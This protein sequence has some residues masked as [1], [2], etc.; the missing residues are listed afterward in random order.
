MARKSFVT[1]LPKH[2]FIWSIL[3]MAFIPL[4]LMFIIS[5]KDNVQFSH[6]PWLPTLPFHW[7]NY[8]VGWEHV[9]ASIWN[10]MF[11]AIS[12]TVLSLIFGVC[13]AFFFARYKMP[14]SNILFYIF[15]ILMLYPGVANMVPTFK[16]ISSLGLYNTH[17]ALILLFVAGSQAFTIYVMRNFIEDL[18]QDLFDAADVDGCSPWRQIWTIVVPL[19]SPIIGTLGVLR[20]IGEW[21]A[22]VGPLIM[23]RDPHKQMIGVRL[24]FL[25]G[26]Y[27]K[28][29]GEM[30]SGYTIASIP[31][32]I[33]F[34]FC[35]RLFV[36]GLSE[37]AIKG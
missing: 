35:M 34:L 8:K 25:E 3:F 36:R 28:K 12:A 5:L 13:G 17:Y 21:N 31:L 27:T 23:L 37:G 1:E 22:F 4:Y 32:I 19:S 30:M 18:P 9:G 16:L 33:L 11:V 2:A 15:I 24:L 6:N 29:W 20:I 14:G 10:T 7:E 26:E